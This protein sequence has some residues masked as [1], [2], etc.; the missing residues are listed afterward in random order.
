MQISWMCACSSA[1][2]CLLIVNNNG[3][4]MLIEKCKCWLKSTVTIRYARTAC[5]RAVKLP[6]TAWPWKP[7]KRE[8]LL[9]WLLVCSKVQLWLQRRSVRSLGYVIGLYPGILDH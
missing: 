6:G 3:V 9:F 2:Q 4:D 1:G 5:F 8:H 7:L